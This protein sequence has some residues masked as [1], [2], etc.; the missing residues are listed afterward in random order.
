MD[1][2]F[3]VDGGR[4]SARIAR[5]SRAHENRG[6]LSPAETARIL[7][8]IKECAE[9]S[10]GCELTTAELES[11]LGLGDDGS[12]IRQYL[13]TKSTRRASAS[14]M[15][16]KNI[17]RCLS[18]ANSNGWMLGEKRARMFFAVRARLT[19][20]ELAQRVV[21]K[22]KRAK[23]KRA[24]IEAA[25]TDL[26]AAAKALEIDAAERASPETLAL[27]AGL[28]RKLRE[29]NQA[30]PEGFPRASACIA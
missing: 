14:G 28:E 22:W 13:K 19:E 6:T 12:Y 27:L 3:G 16:F 8:W 20:V 5:R 24:S 21:Q 25:L 10:A 4:I 30:S 29:A 26:S 11:G 15:S 9:E 18:V 23:R 1:I 7:A 2:L 17:A